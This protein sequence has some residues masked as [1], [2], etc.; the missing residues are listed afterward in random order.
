MTSIDPLNQDQ[1]FAANSSSAEDLVDASALD[2][3][4]ETIKNRF[5]DLLTAL[6]TVTR[7]DDTLID[8]IVRLRNLHP[9][10][11][12]QIGSAAGWQ[13]KQAVDTVA[14]TNVATL[15]GEQTLN[16]VTTELSRVLLTAQTDPTENGPYLT[17]GGD[18][19][20]TTDADT[21]DELGY[22]VYPV[23][24]TPANGSGTVT[25]YPKSTWIVTNSPS[26][27]TIGTTEIV[28]SMIF[29]FDDTILINGSGTAGKIAKFSADRTI[30][31]ATLL[32]ETDD[33]GAYAGSF[34]PEIVGAQFTV[35]KQGG[36]GAIVGMESKGSSSQS[37]GIRA[38]VRNM[39]N[40][41]VGYMEVVVNEDGQVTIAQGTT[42]G[43]QQVKLRI[44]DTGIELLDVVEISAATDATHA[45]QKQQ[46]ALLDGSQAFTAPIA[47]VTPVAANDLA[48]KAYAD[49]AAA[50]NLPN[51]I[52]TFTPGI[53][54][55]TPTIGRKYY[56]ALASGGGGAGGSGP[57]ENNSATYWSSKAGGNGIYKAFEYTAI[58][59]DDW[60]ILVGGGGT[61]GAAGSGGASGGGGGGGS[62]SKIDFNDATNE[63]I[64][65]GG[66]GGGG[67]CSDDNDQN[68]G[69]GGA[70]GVNGTAGT[71]AGGTAG[72]LG[73]GTV[74]GGSG[75]SG[76]L[77]APDVAATAGAIGTSTVTPSS[78]DDNECSWAFPNHTPAG[79]YAG[80]YDSPTAANTTGRNGEDGFCVIRW[81]ES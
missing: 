2:S 14:L 57:T 53:H 75:G 37:N 68:G 52:Q 13:P 40:V 48:T 6:E 44:S 46:V 61:G 49:S 56:I 16:G 41:Q 38:S 17:S 32:G 54:A 78:L 34:E 63:I 80:T 12:A 10:I 5:N 65:G 9:E 22:S 35:T 47:G 67:G 8:I 76:A 19:T 70:G 71:N 77:N 73:A 55:F 72:T 36:D 1:Q 4:L 15:S 30:G 28:M 3:Q 7:D 50:V 27:I 69:N 64:L 66:G 74:N 58:A 18:W 21:A 24:P 25:T 23:A 62:A 51:R 31:D 39:S 26:S 43:S 81:F 33:F 29:Y 60:D 79:G 59:E 20:R 42:E 11:T 45:V